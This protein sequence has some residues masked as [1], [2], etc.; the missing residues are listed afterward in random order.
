MIVRR[1]LLWCRT[2]TARQRAEAVPTLAHAYLHGE[3]S[4]D[5]RAEAETALTAML[6][7]ASPLVRRAL[8]EALADEPAPRHLV[9]ALAQDQSDVAA[10]VLARSP[11]LCDADLV[12]C[13]ALGDGLVQTAIALRPRLSVV[14]CAA[15]AEVAE[16]EALAALAGNPNAEIAPTSLARMIE[17]HGGHG[18]LR[19]ALLARPDLPLDL[20]QA[21]LRALAASLSAFVAERGW[22]PAERVERLSREA[23][24]RTTLALSARS[25]GEEV[26]RLV[27]RL[28]EAGELTPALILRALLSRACAFVE[29]AFAELA[30]LPGERAAGLLR[31]PGGFA[32]LCRRAALPAALQPAFLAARGAI[33]PWPAVDED[34]RLCRKAVA[35]VLAACDGLPPEEAGRVAALLRRFEAEAARE[36]AAAA[37]HSL[38]EDAALATV[39]EQV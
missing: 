9:V 36:E 20:R 14:V 22:L 7:D 4:P 11:V 15:L 39:L 1:F 3:L 8:A 21:V 17:R 25:G 32:A 2:A 16:A 18:P 31:E 5:D 10:L 30:G 23:R 12:D 33:G 24:E 6:D 26:R 19:E 29:A 37:A 35:A 34:V 13:A 27:R 28:R 38:A